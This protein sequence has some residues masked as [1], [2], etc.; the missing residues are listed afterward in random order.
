MRSVKLIPSLAAAAMLLALTPA[1]AS[2]IGRAHKH[3]SPNGRCAVNINVAPAGQITAGDFVLVWGQLRCHGRGS[4]VGAKTVTLLQRTASSG[5]FGV[6]QTTP[7]DAH[8]FYEF[9]VTSVQNTSTFFV[10]SHGAASGRRTVPVAAEV[11]LNEPADGTQLF[12]GPA[13]KVTF[14]GTVSPA[15]VGALVVLQRQNAV[16]GNEWRRID[17]GRVVAGGDLFDHAHVRA[18]RAMPTSACW[19]AAA[20]ATFRASRT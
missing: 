9:N 7:T 1:G 16:T 5:G 11:T 10:R 15:N 19:C 17:S 14:T 13:N 4:S 18:F 3:P 6:A 12:T 20:G 8:G 2:A